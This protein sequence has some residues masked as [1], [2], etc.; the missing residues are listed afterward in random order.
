MNKAATAI[1]EDKSTKNVILL[2][3]K[4]SKRIALKLLSGPDTTLNAYKIHYGVKGNGAGFAAKTFLEFIGFDS[5]KSRSFR[6]DWNEKEQMLE[7]QL[8]ADAFKNDKAAA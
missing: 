5:S 8:P 4:D 6:A 1:L 3:D 2:W 7:V